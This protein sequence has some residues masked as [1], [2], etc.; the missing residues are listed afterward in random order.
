MLSYTGSMARVRLRDIAWTI[1]KQA[2]LEFVEDSAFRYSAAV[3]FYTMISL[4]PLLV[5]VMTMTTVFVDIQ[6]VKSELLFQVGDLIGTHGAATLETVLENAE[7][8][9]QKG[10]ATALGFIVLIFGS[11]AVFAQL[12]DAL[13]RIWGVET[14]PEKIWWSF[15]LT[16]LISFGMVL[17][18]G[19]LLLV[20]LLVT[21][22]LTTISTT[23]RLELPGGDAVW[24][25]IDV[26]SS[27]VI[28]T[29]LFAF[30]F[31]YVP[32]VR[33]AWS[34]VWIGAVITAV[35]FTG[36]KRLIGF[37]LGHSAVT[38]VYGAAGSLV[39]L[40]FWVYYSALIVFFGAEVAQ[41]FTRL[42]GGDIKPR[43]FAFKA[44]P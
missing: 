1:P 15:F 26:V 35:L 7:E 4:A 18:I 11:T 21:T 27:L 44:K 17:A 31:R 6:A 12:Q 41:V 25:S 30:L 20:S 13:N 9:R 42:F 5:I 3:S 34:D 33:I 43:R 23:L 16:R 24:Y 10:T 37:Y 38:S 14:K 32:D 36:G 28:I 39:A 22:V 29:L 40:L 2:V 8:S 19:F